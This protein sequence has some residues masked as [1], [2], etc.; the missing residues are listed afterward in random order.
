MQHR[1]IFRGALVGGA[2]PE[3]RRRGAAYWC[4]GASLSACHS[5]VD[6]IRRNGQYDDADDWQGGR[7][8]LLATARQGLCFIP[9]VLLLPRLFDMWGVLVSQSVPDVIAFAVA[10][11]ITLH[12]FGQMRRA[13]AEG[14][15]I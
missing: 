1:W 12:L 9:A 14:R 15:R 10:L 4:A 13:S 5:A 2:F 11:P 6:G 7:A 8:T 3:K